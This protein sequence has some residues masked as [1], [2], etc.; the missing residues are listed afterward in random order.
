MGSHLGFG[1]AA[2][3][4]K[5]LPDWQ[6]DHPH[7][8]AGDPAAQSDRTRGFCGY[9]A[10]IHFGA[11]PG[12]RRGDRIGDHRDER[13]RAALLA[14]HPKDRVHLQMVDADPQIGLLV[15][16]DDGGAAPQ[17]RI[18]GPLCQDQP[19][20]RGC[21]AV[22]DVVQARRVVYQWAVAG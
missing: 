14:Q 3:L 8:L 6:P 7:T 18:N 10:Q 19:G 13:R 20:A 12:R 2:Q 22:H 1:P 4:D 17:Q 16:H 15:A 11:E 21:K 9:D 5:R